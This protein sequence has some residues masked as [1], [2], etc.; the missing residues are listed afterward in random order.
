VGNSRKHKFAILNSLI[1]YLFDKVLRKHNEV[2]YSVMKAYLKVLCPL[3]RN[4]IYWFK[5]GKLVP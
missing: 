3:S 2:N 5:Y 4:D 1:Q